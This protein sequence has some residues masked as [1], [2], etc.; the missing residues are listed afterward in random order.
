MRCKAYED[1]NVRNNCYRYILEKLSE[2]IPGINVVSIKKKI[3][4]LRSQYLR[5]HKNV[6]ESKKSAAGTDDIVKQK[7]W[8]YDMLSFI[9]E[10]GNDLR[11]SR[12]TLDKPVQL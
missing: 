5:E 3:H 12:S 9:S 11:E 7:L 8:C 2:N 10:N 4:T 6:R 1:R